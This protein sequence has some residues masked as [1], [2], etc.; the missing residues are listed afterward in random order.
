MNYQTDMSSPGYEPYFLA[1][2]YKKALFDEGFAL[3]MRSMEDGQPVL[4]IR[5]KCDSDVMPG[6]L[7]E[8]IAEEDRIANEIEEKEMEETKEDPSVTVHNIKVEELV[9]GIGI[10]DGI[11][12]DIPKDTVFGVEVSDNY[13]ETVPR[14]CKQG[15]TDVKQAVEYANK[16]FNEKSNGNI[17]EGIKGKY[18]GTV[19]ISMQ[20]NGE[21]GMIYG[22]TIGSFGSC[23]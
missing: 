21:Q 17:Y 13:F 15:L 10:V 19:I 23:G 5:K 22:L 8:W 1:Y 18:V 16:I 12:E 4:F 3:E 6:T 20:E 11:D 14:L 9:P 7:E 2:I